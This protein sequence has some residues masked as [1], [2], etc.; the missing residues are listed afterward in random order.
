MS[1]P[2]K[3]TEE[4]LTKLRELQSDFNNVIIK[5][6]QLHIDEINLSKASVR[7]A[8]EK[9]KVQEEFDSITTR[10][11]T[12][13]DELNAKYGAGILDPATGLFTPNK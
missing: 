12:I 10:E 4:E 6:G 9:M 5:F 2:V 1:E 13:G 7:L 11:K 3:F 8:A